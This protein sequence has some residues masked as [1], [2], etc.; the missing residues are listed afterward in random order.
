MSNILWVN[1]NHK[2]LSSLKLSLLQKIFDDVRKAN[3]GSLQKIIPVSGDIT[4]DG[5]ELSQEDES[6]LINSVSIIFHCAANV[7]FNDPLEEAININA[8]GTLRV[9]QLAEKMTQLKS[10]LYMSTSF[11]QSYQE[12]LEERYY[13]TNLDVFDIIEKTQKMNDIEL[14][15]FEKNMWV[16]QTS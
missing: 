1:V 5:L 4:I 13:P 7:K 16:W 2:L 9:L 3:E 6:S 11:C 15:Q 12:H 14:N 8:T 10:F